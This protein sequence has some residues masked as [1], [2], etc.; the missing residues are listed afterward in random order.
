MEELQIRETFNKI[1][2]EAKAKGQVRDYITD[3]E[4]VQYYPI[5]GCNAKR[6]RYFVNHEGLKATGRVKKACVFGIREV[7]AA[8]EWKKSRVRWGA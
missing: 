6:V 8:M 5:M 3:E 4:L 7:I 1:L 2:A